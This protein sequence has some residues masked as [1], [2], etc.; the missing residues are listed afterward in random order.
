MRFSASHQ[1]LGYSWYYL[2]K[3]DFILMKSIHFFSS[4][5]IAFFA[6]H[7]KL[8]PTPGC[9]D[10][11]LCSSRSSAGLAFILKSTIHFKLIFCVRDG[12]GSWLPCSHVDIRLFWQHLLNFRISL[13]VPLLMF[14][15]GLCWTVTSIWEAMTS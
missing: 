1:L 11:L 9:K 12:R 4:L 8:L 14:W 7:K 15:L 13:S 2:R 3:S 10:I 6:L 5:F